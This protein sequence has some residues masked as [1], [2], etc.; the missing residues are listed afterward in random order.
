MPE[1]RGK[2]VLMGSG[3]LTATMVE[4]H[5]SLLH[6]PGGRPEAVFLDTPA[7]F[8]LNVDH[9]ARKAAAYFESRIGCPLTLVSYKSAESVDPEQ[10]VRITQTL[11][12]SGYI[13]IGPGSP[14]YALN[15][16]RASR[17]PDALIDQV[18]SGGCLVTASAAALTVGRYTLPV[19]EIY[20]VGQAPHWV[21]G[22]DILGHFGFNTVVVPH[23]NNAEGGNHDTRFC[24]MGETR[25]ARLE[26]LLPEPA[27]I[28]GLDEHTALI[29]DFA[30]QQA[31]VN[32][33][34]RVVLRRNGQ[35][36]IF[37]KDDVVPL[38]LLRGE[39]Q[40]AP[41]SVSPAAAQPTEPAGAQPD[42]EVWRRLHSQAD[43]VRD[44]LAAHRPEEATTAMLALEH[45]VWE[46]QQTLQDVDGLGAARELLREAMVLTGNRL[47]ALPPSR[48]AC[49]DPLVAALLSLRDQFRS[50][51]QWASADA[52]RDCLSSA[53][54]AVEDAADG[55]RW[56]MDGD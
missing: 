29:I 49:L 34:G 15:Q 43:Q 6:G 12:Q 26:A 23:W 42:A 35:D 16:W 37:N 51:R 3:E 38:S 48:R 5:K 25:F 40:E 18:A 24:F 13:L 36:R 10:S 22:L 11:R 21:E 28:L 8:Q 20:K 17:I 47:A 7:G 56:S 32:G 30:E 39:T 44:A 52:L 54:I 9:I 46:N 53:G 14:T 45:L 4:L 55:T 19:Y 2:L 50:R 33:I 1:N 41:R 27:D 31:R